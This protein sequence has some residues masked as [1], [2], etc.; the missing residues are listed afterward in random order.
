MKPGVGWNCYKEV[1]SIVSNQE[2]L[3]DLL[4]GLMG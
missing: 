2:K 4:R 1:K 3:Q